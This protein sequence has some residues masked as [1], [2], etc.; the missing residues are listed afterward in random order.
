MRKF[1]VDNFLR[2]RFRDEDNNKL[3]MSSRT[4]SNM[5]LIYER[6][7]RLLKS[8]LK[9]CGRHYEFLA[10]SS[11]QLREHGCWLYLNSGRKDNAERVRE[12]M[13]DFSKIKCV[14]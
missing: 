12:W 13:G 5:S 8:G 14:G 1:G 11:S 4:I 6:I 3:N 10:M 7:N 9:I 2:I